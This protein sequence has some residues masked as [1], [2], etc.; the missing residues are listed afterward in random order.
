MAWDRPPEI[1]VNGVLTF[2]S[3]RYHIVGSEDF[4]FHT[5][6]GS[7]ERTTLRD[8]ANYTTY[9]VFIAA[10]SINGTGPFTSQTA[11]TSENGIYYTVYF[12][13]KVFFS[14]FAHSS[15]GSSTEHYCK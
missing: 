10:L 1:D 14:K 7:V 13:F 8:L 9:E 12:Y 4:E 15:R 2:Y 11:K 6:N 3:L 5:V